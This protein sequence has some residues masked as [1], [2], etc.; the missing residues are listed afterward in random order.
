MTTRP[1]ASDFLNARD[2]IEKELKTL[3]GLATFDPKLLQI[4]NSLAWPKGLLGLTHFTEEIPAS[5]DAFNETIRKE[6]DR[7]EASICANQAV[8]WVRKKS[9]FAKLE[10]S[11]KLQAKLKADSK[12]GR[13]A[14]RFKLLQAVL[15][16][17]GQH[18]L[19]IDHRHKPGQMSSK[20]WDKAIEAVKA[21]RDLEENNGLRLWK[22][23]PLTMKN[24]FGWFEQ[25]EQRLNNEKATAKKPYNDGLSSD[26]A[27]T[28]LF[29]E[30]LLMLFN[31]AP[32]SMVEKFADLIGY[33]TSSIPRQVKEWEQA[34]RT[35]SLT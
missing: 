31:E 5:S 10:A 1:K 17:L 7:V 34:H 9:Q 29:T 8:I 13:P 23:F 11:L 20:D 24:S 12:F 33:E 6:V 28:R 32:P 16:G 18:S 26:R 35:D 3:D 19:Y 27:A 30:W 14:A 4:T 25:L 21:L 2:Q 15:M 22:V